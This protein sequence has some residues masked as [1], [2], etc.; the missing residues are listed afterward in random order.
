MTSGSAGTAYGSTKELY[1]LRFDERGRIREIGMVGSFVK[2]G[3]GVPC[4]YNCVLHCQVSNLC[5]SNAFL[6]GLRLDLTR[7]CVAW[8]RSA[9]RR[10]KSP[11]WAAS[12]ACTSYRPQKYGEQ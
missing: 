3:T 6:S 5:Q 11:S 8:E 9:M 2:T 12:R 4:P 1:E 7:W 10:R